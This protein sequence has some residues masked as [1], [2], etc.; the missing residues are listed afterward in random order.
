MPQMSPMWWELLFISFLMIY[1]LMNSIM[2]WNKE[3]IM[4]SEKSNKLISYLKWKW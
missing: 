4:K 3:E 1:M 2:Y